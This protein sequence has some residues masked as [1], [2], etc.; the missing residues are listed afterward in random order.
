ML[1]HGAD[2]MRRTLAAPSDYVSYLI[3][4][5]RVAQQRARTNTNESS[6]LAQFNRNC[7]VHF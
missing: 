6:L 5:Q 7:F 1:A 3:K 2:P 4:V